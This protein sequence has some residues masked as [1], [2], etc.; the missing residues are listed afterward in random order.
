MPETSKDSKPEAGRFRFIDLGFG[1]YSQV[2]GRVREF[3]QRRTEGD[4]CDTIFLAEHAPVYTLGKRRGS[5]DCFFDGDAAKSGQIDG[6]PIIQ[7]DRGGLATYHGPGQLMV[8]PVIALRPGEQA[9]RRLVGS[10]ERLGVLI[11]DRYGVTAFARDDAPGVWTSQGKFA[12]IGLSVHRMVTL[13]GMGL[14]VSVDVEAYGRLDPCGIPDGGPANL[15][16]LA[17]GVSVDQ[18]KDDVVNLWDVVWNA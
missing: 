9:V 2:F 13:H 17:G 1:D 8:Y 15:S 5:I 18:V 10:L 14:N 11:A 6:V 4:G 16:D 3:H 12:A 7:A